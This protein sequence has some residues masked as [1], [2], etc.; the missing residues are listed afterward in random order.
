LT[1][2][3]RIILIVT[4]SSNRDVINQEPVRGE[5]FI[6]AS[7][8]QFSLDPAILYIDGAPSRM[9]PICVFIITKQ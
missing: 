2:A 3:S 1:K 6:R 5:R 8:S 9:E 7:I 4:L